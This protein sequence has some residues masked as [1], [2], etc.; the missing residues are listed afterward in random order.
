MLTWLIFLMLLL[1]FEF[2]F[3]W[4]SPRGCILSESS[5]NCVWDLH[6]QKFLVFIQAAQGK[7]I[8]SYLPGKL[9]LES[10]PPLALQIFSDT[11][12]YL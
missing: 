9:F 5:F 1:K 10:A 11:D 4:S 6:L 8:N 12:R 2:G 7:Q 3:N